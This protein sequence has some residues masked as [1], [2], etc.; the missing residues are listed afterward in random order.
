MSKALLLG[1]TGLVGGECLT[2]ILKD[3]FFSHVTAITRK[4]MDIKHSKLTNIISDFVDVKQL[5]QT[6]EFDV[7]FSVIGSTISKAG[8]QKKFREIDFDIPYNVASVCKEYGVKTHILVSALGADA[9]SSIFYNKVKG[10]LENAILSLE[11]DRC[12]ILR[13]SLLIGDRKEHRFG[14]RVAQLLFENLK[15]IFVGPL[16]KYAGVRASQVAN[17]MISLSKSQKKKLNLILENK[18][19]I[20]FEQ[21][22]L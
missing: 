19:I 10:E 8:S 6:Q 12:I 21:N 11:F 9:N 17:A 20:S 1:A 22:E 18:D 7:V 16:Q 3:D 14:E 4:P 13:P 15:F 5:F 2:L